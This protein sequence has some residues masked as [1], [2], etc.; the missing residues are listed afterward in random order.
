MAMNRLR[1]VLA[2]ALLALLFL[3]GCSGSGNPMSSADEA[4][5]DSLQADAPPAERESK[6]TERAIIRTGSVRLRSDDVAA[7]RDDA[8]DVIAKFGGTIGSEDAYTDEDGDVT[9]ATL[10]V[11]VPEESFVEAISALKAVGELVSVSSSAEDVTTQVIDNDVRVRAQRR[12]IRRIE[13]LLDRAESMQDVIRI[14]EELT[15][16]QTELDS[17]AQQ[18]AYLKDQTAMST[19]ELSIS[20]TADA[21]DDRDGFLGG[22]E[23]GWSALVAFGGGLLTLTGWLLPWLLVLTVLLLTPVLLL[24]RVTRRRSARIGSTPPTAPDPSTES[25]RDQG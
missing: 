1:T 14:E 17:L 21:P 20:R 24:R 15:K 11:R 6:P 8:A 7:T 5:G 16:R 13:V 12:S 3:T 22:L 19:I 2:A 4:G 18:Q 10:T 9:D 23:S 25:P